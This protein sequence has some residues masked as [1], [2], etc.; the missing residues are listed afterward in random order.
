MKGFLEGLGKVYPD[1]VEEIDSE[2]LSPGSKLQKIN[3]QHLETVKHLHQQKA[4]VDGVIINNNESND[5]NELSKNLDYTELSID[6]AL[7]L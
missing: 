3:L 4:N 1:F 7:H 2:V 5:K 6:Y